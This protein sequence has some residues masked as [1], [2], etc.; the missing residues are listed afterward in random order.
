MEFLEIVTNYIDQ[1][2]WYPIDLIYLDFQKAFD[3]VRL[4]M[5]INAIWVLQEV[6][7]IGLKIGLTIESRELF[8]WGAILNG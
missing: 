5:K 4:M 7:L 6:Y 1:W 3:K 2:Q 8:F